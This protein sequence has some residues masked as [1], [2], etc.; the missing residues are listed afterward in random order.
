MSL[1]RS[2]PHWH[3]HLSSRLTDTEY[4]AGQVLAQLSS[5]ANVVVQGELHLGVSLRS[6]RAENVS[7][8]VKQVLDLEP[9][10][11]ARTLRQVSER[12]LPCHFP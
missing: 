4:G 9:E 10:Q 7:L 12:Y 5:R 8:L 2:F 1:Q 11:A 6:F 3:I